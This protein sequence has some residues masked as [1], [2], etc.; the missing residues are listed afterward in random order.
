MTVNFGIIGNDAAIVW[1]IETLS[2]DGVTPVDLSLAENIKVYL[3]YTSTPD[4][5]M[6]SDCVQVLPTNASTVKVRIPGNHPKFQKTGFINAV[7]TF[8]M[9]EGDERHYFRTYRS[10]CIQ[11]FAH[12]EQVEALI[13]KG[14]EFNGDAVLLKKSTTFGNFVFEVNQTTIVVDEG[15]L[16]VKA[17]TVNGLSDS[18]KK[19][20]TSAAVKQ[21]LD[22]CL[23]VV[24]I[25]FE[26]EPSRIYAILQANFPQA[27][28]VTSV[29]NATY[30]IQA[31]CDN[32]TYRL[33]YVT[34]TTVEYATVTPDSIQLSYSSL[35][36]PENE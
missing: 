30:A 26:D 15:M 12:T 11:Y 18:D 17:T 10:K 35:Y 34:P 7:M 23:K 27:L 29:E 24:Q 22:R 36:I 20:P 32:E 8:E 2:S 33:Q 6:E 14:A 28:F 4:T 3:G 13:A 19:I 21:H 5:L 31:T 16:D 1:S 9:V 25:D